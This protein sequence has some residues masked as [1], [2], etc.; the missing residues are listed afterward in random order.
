MPY[1]STSPTLILNFPLF[2]FFQGTIMPIVAK[3]DVRKVKYLKPKK[4]GID[5]SNEIDIWS[6]MEFKSRQQVER[7]SRNSSLDGHEI[8][9]DL[10]S[11]IYAIREK[12]D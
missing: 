10:N 9:Q 6:K 2:H 3:V 12:I 5:F 4:L 11:L 7:L 8:L 1:F